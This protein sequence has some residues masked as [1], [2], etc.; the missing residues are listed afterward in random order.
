MATGK[1][2]LVDTFDCSTATPTLQQLNGY[3]T[4][5]VWS[6]KVF[7][8]PSAL[9]TVLAQYVDGGGGVVVGLFAVY[10]GWQLT[11]NWSNG[12]SCLNVGNQST[13]TLKLQANQP[14]SPLAAG[15]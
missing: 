1:F 14:N 3:T 5:L 8:S 12:Y 13:G 15:I 7:L 4:V 10:S 2:V 6:D 11:G 9:G